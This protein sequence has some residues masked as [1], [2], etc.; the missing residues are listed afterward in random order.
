MP[1]RVLKAGLALAALQ[2][3][4]MGFA[5]V[6][7]LVIPNG[8]ITG[9]IPTSLFMAAGV[10]LF[11][12]YGRKKGRKLLPF[13][14]TAGRKLFFVVVTVLSGFLVLS[15]LVF[16][17]SPQGVYMLLY[18]CILTPVFEEILF[19]GILWGYLKEDGKR[20]WLVLAAV[21]LLFGL[22]HIGYIDS[23]AWRVQEGGLLFAMGMKVLIGFVLG[24][25]T[26]LTRLKSGT[27]YY[28]ILI[29]SVWNV[30]AR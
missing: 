3:L 17:R 28:G 14:D 16:D 21:T 1:G 19:R 20:E 25:F 6:F 9:H 27:V 18:A 22:W 5:Q 15:S 11:L 10:L 24:T 29:H 26:G 30:F 23:I 2:L 7:Y 13:L 8:I 4:R 12:R